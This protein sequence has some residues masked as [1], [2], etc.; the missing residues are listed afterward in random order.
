MGGVEDRTTA[1]EAADVEIFDALEAL[2]VD[3]VQYLFSP[4]V[5]AG[6]LIMPMLTL[7][8]DVIGVFGA[9]LVAVPLSGVDEGFFFGNIRRMVTYDDVFQG[10]ITGTVFG[11]LMTVIACRQGCRAAGGARGVGEATTSAVVWSSVA[12]LGTNYIL[13]ALLL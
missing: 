4:R 3:P 7:Y 5:V 9:W 2:A 11:A 8:F 12:I 6:I 10:V 1:L 13:T